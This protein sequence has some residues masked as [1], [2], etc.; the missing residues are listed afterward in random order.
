LFFIGGCLY[1]CGGRDQNCLILNTCEKYDPLT[2]KWT[3]LPRMNHARVGF[4]LVA[5]D[6]N[7]YAI[8]GSNDMTE[9]LTSVEGYHT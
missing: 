5:I 6:D 7:I 3:E 2:N 1:A 9:P 8:G 4:G